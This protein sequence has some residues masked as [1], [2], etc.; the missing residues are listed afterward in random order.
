[1]QGNCCY[2]FILCVLHGYYGPIEVHLAIGTTSV[3]CRHRSAFRSPLECAMG[4]MDLECACSQV[5][6]SMAC[7]ATSW[8][9][10]LHASALSYLG[11]PLLASANDAKQDLWLSVFATLAHGT[12]TLQGLHAM[13][14]SQQT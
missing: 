3:D 5:S 11:K 1:M 14:A 9:N 12:A 13:M 2:W 6:W 7:S 4:K 8:T 10:I